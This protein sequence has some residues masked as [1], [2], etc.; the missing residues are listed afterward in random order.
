[1]LDTVYGVC[2]DDGM[3]TDSEKNIMADLRHEACETHCDHCGQ[4]DWEHTGP[5]STRPVPMAKYD[6]ETLCNDCAP[7]SWLDRLDY[8]MRPMDRRFGLWCARH[9]G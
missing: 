3:Y 7:S 8:W 6:T 2:D 5:M 1:M 4:C 9:F